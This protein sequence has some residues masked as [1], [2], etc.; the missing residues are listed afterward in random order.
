M[1]S[2]LSLADAARVWV[3]VTGDGELTG[4]ALETSIDLE[5]T[6]EVEVT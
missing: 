4:N 6:V 3:I 2:L 5:F 1:P